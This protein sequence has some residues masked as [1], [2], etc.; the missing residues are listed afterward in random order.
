M[1]RL[2]QLGFWRHKRHVKVF[3]DCGAEV[4]FEN[5]NC[6]VCGSFLGFETQP[7]SLIPIKAAQLEP[8]HL[9]VSGKCYK[10]CD[11]LTQSGC[12]WLL[13]ADK[14][15]QCISC[16]LTRTIPTLTIDRNLIRWQ[17][18]ELTK[19]RDL[20]RPLGLPL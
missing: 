18:L 14:F 20:Y 17:R 5:I 2:P 3:C 15:G 13:E 16:R 4:F 6:S 7:Q 10:I 9:S 19:R 1:I 8:W 12:N 11:L